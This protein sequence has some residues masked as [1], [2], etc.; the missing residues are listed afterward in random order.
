MLIKTIEKNSEKE[1]QLHNN[2][3]LKYKESQL[4]FS[5][6]TLLGET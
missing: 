3:E 1:S 4:C 2:T 5:L 6:K